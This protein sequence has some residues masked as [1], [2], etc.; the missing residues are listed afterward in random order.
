MY[1]CVTQ[2]SPPFVIQV[3]QC[4]AYYEGYVQTMCSENRFSGPVGFSEILVPAC[5]PT[6]TINV[7]S[8]TAS[9]VSCP[10]GGISTPDVLIVSI[11]LSAPVS[12]T[13]TFL[14]RV[15]YKFDNDT[16][17]YDTYINIVVNAGSSSATLNCL[18]GYVDYMTGTRNVLNVTGISHNNTVEAINW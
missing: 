7:T 3:P 2:A 9:F 12:V 8:K 4:N 13:T 10:A 15:E 14:L 6:T 16:T 17:I 18:D 5:S 1:N 11:S